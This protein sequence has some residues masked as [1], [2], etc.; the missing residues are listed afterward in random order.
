MARPGLGTDK[1]IEVIRELEAT[2]REPTATAVRERLGSGSYSTIAAVLTDWRREKARDTRTPIPEPPDSVRH[3]LS[4]LWGEAWK[5]ALAVHEPERQAFARAR[6][7]HEQITSEMAAEI[8]RLEGE[9]EREKEQAARTLQGLQG[10]L[11]ALAEER[12]RVRDELQ[13][14]LAASAA[15]EGALAEARTQLEREAKRNEDLSQRVITEAAK[16][17]ALAARVGEL[18]GA[19]QG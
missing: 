16:A 10:Q 5:A 18:E 19:K 13:T 9:L 3:L 4:H 1:I 17:Q 7:E 6:A 12:D 15:A 11:T 8:T 2:G 14:A